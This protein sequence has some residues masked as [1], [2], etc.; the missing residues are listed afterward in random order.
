M[1]WATLRTQ[2]TAYFS[3][4][5]LLRGGDTN[6][7]ISFTSE[8]KPTFLGPIDW[9]WGESDEDIDQTLGGV[10]SQY[11]LY[12]NQVE[13]LVSEA[14]TLI[15][16]SL[17]DLLQYDAL[18]V[19]RF[20]LFM[21]FLESDKTYSQQQAE[22]ADPDFWQGLAAEQDLL[23]QARTQASGNTS[24]IDKNYNTADLT[25]NKILA[26]GGAPASFL[27]S[28]AQK[29]SLLSARAQYDA[30]VI[31][32][33][34]E[35]DSSAA[36]KKY[37]TQSRVHQVERQQIVRDIIQMKLSEFQ[38]PGGALNYN[39]RML[40]IGARAKNDFVETFARLHAIVV[41]LREFYDVLEPSEADLSNDLATSRTRI[42]G[43]VTWLRK[44]ANTLSRAK[45]GEQQT[46]IR[47]TIE[48]DNL[49]QQ[50]NDGLTVVFSDALVAKM[51]RPRLIG[52]SATTA[53]DNDSWVDLLV[54]CPSQKLE[55]ANVTLPNVAVRLGRASS[56][57]S[58]NVRDIAGA[59]PLIN[60]SPVGA[61]TVQAVQDF[62]G[63]NV[64]RVDLDF[65]LVFVQA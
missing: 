47:T 1:D 55:T 31:A 63:K 64:K 33:K 49:I 24:E 29:Y 59:R 20:K 56:A 60:R 35:S 25:Y 6:S 7:I 44:A 51:Q 22:Q 43:A 40:Q 12:C 57:G 52:L 30:Q 8:I 53:Y 11:L 19:E 9:T 37:E 13:V 50:L 48:N 65:H 10:R 14:G 16:R 46:V 58:L 2:T 54:T 32:N 41:G 26:A 28:G 38:R 4:K 39:E 61:W 23:S 62:K 5:K 15:E 3:D 18:N 27:P 45:I 42:E 34:L 17:R 21:E 36:R